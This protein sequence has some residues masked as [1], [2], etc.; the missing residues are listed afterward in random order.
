MEL[1]IEDKAILAHVVIDPDAWI[2]HAL[3]TVGEQAV[4]AKVERWKPDYLKEK[5]RLG[6]NYKTR[7]EVEIIQEANK[8][9]PTYADLRRPA[10][11]PIG[12]QLDNIT[13][14]LKFLMENGIKIGEWGELQVK[15]CMDVK[16]KYP[17]PTV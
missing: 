11:P 17:K 4:T 3:K 7:A 14:A 8:P 6:E 15:M 13:K 10:Y 12:D 16:A 5:E 1:S 2:D 9:I